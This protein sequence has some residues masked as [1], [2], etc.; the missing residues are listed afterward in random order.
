MNFK[1]GGFSM[2]MTLSVPADIADAARDAA[3]KNGDI[4][5]QLL[6]DALRA[7][8]PPIPQALKQEFEAL[9]RASDEDFL[10][11]EQALGE[12]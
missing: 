11:F 2:R 3:E 5:E 10:R 4:P 6:I 7:Y 1:E 8:F 9:E 12:G